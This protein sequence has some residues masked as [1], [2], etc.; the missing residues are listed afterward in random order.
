MFVSTCVCKRACASDLKL[1]LF[2]WLVDFS[3]SPLLCV[4]GEKKSLHSL[5]YGHFDHPFEI[6]ALICH[7]LS[8]FSCFIYF[9]ATS[10]NFELSVG[11]I[12]GFEAA[13]PKLLFLIRH[14]FQ[15]RIVYRVALR[16]AGF[17]HRLHLVFYFFSALFSLLTAGKSLRKKE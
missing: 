1:L 8:S 2:L 3:V 4:K 13:F 10:F 9:G 17:K 12:F 16:C 11:K 14:F 7:F 15:A 6:P 5:C